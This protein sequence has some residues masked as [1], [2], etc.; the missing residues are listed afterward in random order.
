MKYEYCCESPVEQ[1]LYHTVLI[2]ASK[3][4]GLL[5]WSVLQLVANVLFNLVG[6]LLETEQGTVTEN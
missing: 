4:L 2:L 1:Q 3:Q 5:L 6:K